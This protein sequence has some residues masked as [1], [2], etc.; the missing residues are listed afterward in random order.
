MGLRIIIPPQEAGRLDRS[1]GH[2][3]RT[4]QLLFI[5]ERLTFRK[6]GASAR[7]D[8]LMMEYRVFWPDS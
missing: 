5:I 4:T 6:H 8:E 2:Q 3:V 7:R 1:P